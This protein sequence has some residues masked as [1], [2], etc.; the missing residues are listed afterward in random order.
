M[1]SHHR[2]QADVPFS[3]SCIDCDCDSPHCYDE[4]L[5]AGWTEI[6]F[7]PDMPTENYLGLC[8]VCTARWNAPAGS[9]P[10]STPEGDR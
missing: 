6:Q 3:L 9:T 5:A 4:A 8:P 1:D 2:D 7:T 10:T